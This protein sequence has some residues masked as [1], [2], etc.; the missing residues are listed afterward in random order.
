MKRIGCHCGRRESGIC[1]DEKGMHLEA[2]PEIIV[3]KK[4]SS[5]KMHRYQIKMLPD[6]R[7]IFC[8]DGVTQ[9]GLGS[10][11]LKGGWKR[12]GLIDYTKTLL[13]KNPDSPAGSLPE[14]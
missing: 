13:T 2:E 8:S 10:P 4:F 11:G 9:A 12:T 7:L 6:D 3:S 14:G 1:L 5:R